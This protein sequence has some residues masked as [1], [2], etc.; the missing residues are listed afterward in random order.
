[1]HIPVLSN[2]VIKYLNPQKNEN[3]VDA[4]FGSGGHT[5]TILEHTAPKG[6]IL[7]LDADQQAVEQ[8]QALFKKEPRLI[9][10][11][12]N[13]AHIQERA[14]QVKFKPVHGILFDLGFSSNHLEES[15][16]GF[17]FRKDEPL[18]M[19]Y[20]I[21][22]PITAEKIVNFWSKPDLER[23]LKEYGEEQYAKAI[24][25][26]IVQSRGAKQITKTLQLVKIIEEAVPSFYRKQKIHPATKTFQALRIATN[27]ELEN[28]QAALPQAVELVE[29]KGTIVV[30][31]FHSLEDRIVKHFF[32]Q[33]PRV[34]PITKKPVEA[35]DQEIQ[36]NPRARSAKLR[37]AQKN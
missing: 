35:T 26:H 15:G 37:A 10:V 28:L 23:I 31:S 21:T 29:S 33:E 5:K 36:T 17:T 32:A 14:M 27:Q 34:Q 2:E 3:F 4:T 13:F 1:M 16:R 7:A 6:K 22:N 8:G 30:I 19:R 12:E 9:L 25:E 20:D 18:D 11:H 24:A